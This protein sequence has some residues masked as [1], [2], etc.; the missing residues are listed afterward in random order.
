[1]KDILY[2]MDTIEK[3]SKRIQKAE[4]ILNEA[5]ES[6]NRTI[7]FM[8]FNSSILTKEDKDFLFEHVIK[9]GLVIIRAENIIIETNN[10]IQE[11]I[12]LIEEEPK[13]NHQ[14]SIFGHKIEIIH[15]KYF[16]II[17][18]VGLILGMLLF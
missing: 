16:A 13:A 15:I 9:Y 7:E 17:F 14:F 10:E 3:L 11:L 5:V 12:D 4:N 8:E 2:L 18:I 1:M 6:R